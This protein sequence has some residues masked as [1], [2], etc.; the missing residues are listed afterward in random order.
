MGGAV[1][2]PAGAGAPNDAFGLPRRFHVTGDA[3]L[4][5][6]WEEDVPE[7]AGPPRHIHTSAAE[8]FVVRTGRVLFEAD[9]AQFEAGAGDTVL[10]PM[11][12]PH[13]FKG[14]AP[15]GS[16]VLITLSPGGGDAFFRAVSDE[17]LSPATDMPRITEL[18]ELYDV[19]FV[20]PPL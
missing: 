2:T 11:G 5:S 20:G 6:V 1:H 8:L 12:V 7:G 10:I 19:A 18:A 17:G 13:A 15:D 3:T 16:V 14:L 9:G 4:P